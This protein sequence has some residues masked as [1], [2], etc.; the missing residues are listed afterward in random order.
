MT[1]ELILNMNSFHINT[2]KSLIKIRI[3]VL[4]RG[5][6]SAKGLL[7]QAEGVEF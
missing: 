7:A 3:W 4:G 5:F 1:T 2:M 6:S